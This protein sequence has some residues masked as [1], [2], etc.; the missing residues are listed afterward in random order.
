VGERGDPARWWRTKGEN[1][2]P[3]SKIRTSSPEE[4]GEED[5]ETSPRGEWGGK[6]D[7]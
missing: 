3:V 7:K 4:L 6:K 2:H 5:V 1:K